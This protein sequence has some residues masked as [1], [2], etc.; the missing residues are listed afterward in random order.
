[1]DECWVIARKAWKESRFKKC[2]SKKRC[3]NCFRKWLDNGKLPE[4]KPPLFP[5][6]Y[7]NNCPLCGTALSKPH[8]CI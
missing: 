5:P 8:I 3:E 2:M 1:M 4:E 7:D 6:D